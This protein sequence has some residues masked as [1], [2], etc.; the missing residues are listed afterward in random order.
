MVVDSPRALAYL[1]NQGCITPYAWLSRT[2][3]LDRPDQMLFDLDPSTDR[4]EDVRRAAAMTGELLDE[5]GLASYVKTTGSRGFHVV[6][7]LR[8]REVFDDTRAFA[9]RVA[10]FLT[11][12]APALLT[13][14]PDKEK[15]GD[16]VYIDVMRND[17]GQA[18]VPPYA[19]R[20]LP[21][22]PVATPIEWY[23]LDHT[24]PGEFTMTTARRR[25]AQRGDPWNGIRRRGQELVKARM[26]LARLE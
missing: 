16:R 12:R 26:K 10:E 13:V 22:A 15:R 18:V 4:V 21:G 7:P 23:E 6:V 25:I 8:P 20:A 5:I 1:T 11:S 19:V 2:N 3:A 17:Y 24:E 9:M 14:E